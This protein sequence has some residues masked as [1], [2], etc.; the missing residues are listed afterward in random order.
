MA[1][2]QAAPLSRGE[3]WVDRGAGGAA[4]CMPFSVVVHRSVS[5]LPGCTPAGQRGGGVRSTVMPGVG[6][7]DLEREG[8][9]WRC[10]LGS[11]GLCAR[12][13]CINRGGHI[14]ISFVWL[15]S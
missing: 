12:G 2:R 9:A 1:V 6:R 11:R 15:R 8:R 3:A 5:R 14:T 13:C 4:V 10:F 7:C